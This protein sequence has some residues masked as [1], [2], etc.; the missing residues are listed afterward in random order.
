MQAV[1]N[2]AGGRVMMGEV[3]TDADVGH[4]KASLD[5]MLAALL[6]LTA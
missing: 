5:V 6:S 3:I 4:Q 2:P 1:L